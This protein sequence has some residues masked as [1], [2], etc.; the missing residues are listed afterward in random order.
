MREIGK[1][2]NFD[3]YFGEIINDN[4]EIYLLKKEE[5]EKD[6]TINN[7]DIVSFV[8]EHYKNSE[9]DKKIARFVKKIAQ[10]N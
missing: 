6:I 2:R 3:G 9:L 8:P 5:V 1:V 10:N 4:G 7:N